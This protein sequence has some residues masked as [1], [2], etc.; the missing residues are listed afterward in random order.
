MLKIRASDNGSAVS[1][2]MR[3]VTYIWGL[4]T[5]AVRILVSSVDHHI[6]SQFIFT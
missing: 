4:I 3:L 1:A 6:I 5:G 2:M